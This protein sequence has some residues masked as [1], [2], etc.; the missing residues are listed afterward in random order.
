MKKTLL[1]LA[2]IL[3]ILFSGC[4]QAGTRKF[5]NPQQQAFDDFLY[6]K[7]EASFS[8][9][10]DIQKKEYYSQ[11][12]KELYSYVDSIGLL[13]NWKGM[14]SSI[15]TEER[16]ATTAL[17]FKITYQPEQYRSVEFHCTHL[18]ANDSLNN[19]YI[20]NTLKNMP[21]NMVVYFDGV[22]RTKN[23]GEVYYYMSSAGNDLNIA[24][25]KYEFWITD[26]SPEIRDNSLSE[27]MDK[28]VSLA[29]KIN[30]PLKAQYLGLI[31][32]DESDKQF[33]ELLP[34]FEQA[35]SELSDSERQYIQRLNTCLTY[36]YLYGGK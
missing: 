4:E 24:Y 23:N 29:Y 9:N 8:Q 10:N 30:E 13:V 31:T 18:I 6:K 17:R 7:R 12:E 33:N 22:I 3:P 28:A 20:Y 25:P 27:N 1:T 14:I 34:A 32:K 5:S 35:K 21:N 16:G 11:F 26:I 19:D 15:K 36:N 2:L